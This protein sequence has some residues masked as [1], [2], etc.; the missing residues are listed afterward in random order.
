MIIDGRRKPRPTLVVRRSG[1][2]WT[3]AW[4]YETPPASGTRERSSRYHIMLPDTVLN[5]IANY[6]YV[7][8]NSLLIFPRF[9]QIDCVEKLIEAVKKNRTK[10][11]YLI[12]HSAGSGKTN[13]ISWLAYRLAS[14]HVYDGARAVAVFDKVIIITDRRTVDRQLQ[15]AIIDG[16]RK[17]R[18]TLVV[19]RSG[20]NW[21]RAWEYE[22]PPAS[23]TRERS[24]RYHGA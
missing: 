24:S 8:N 12:Q 14:L 4:E 10:K 6:I 22:T 7:D 23:G 15:Q 16:R 17:P 2:N 21:T 9:H 18:P 1:G 5:L 3:R 20:G 13:E 19:R 11:D